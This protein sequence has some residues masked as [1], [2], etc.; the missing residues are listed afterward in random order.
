VP[1]LD[2]PTPSHEVLLQ[3][4]GIEQHFLP[5]GV[6]ALRTGQ[7]LS[8]SRPAGAGTAS[9]SAGGSRTPTRLQWLPRAPQRRRSA[10]L[11]FAVVLLPPRES[12]RRTYP[13]ARQ[14]V[15]LTPPRVS[16]GVRSARWGGTSH[17]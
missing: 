16:G 13:L 11:P 2:D 3:G 1:V 5:R 15:N 17:T 10:P 7:A 8:S 12:A 14:G 9:D 6:R 4:G